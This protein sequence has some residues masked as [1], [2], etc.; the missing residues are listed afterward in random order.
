MS[1][2]VE[3]PLDRIVNVNW[4]AALSRSLTINWSADLIDPNSLYAP[5]S[6]TTM[7]VSTTNLPLLSP[8]TLSVGPNTPSD[9]F[10]QEVFG[11]FPDGPDGTING[12]YFLRQV[13]GTGNLTGFADYNTNAARPFG[14]AAVIQLSLAVGLAEL[15]R[16]SGHNWN[17]TAFFHPGSGELSQTLSGTAGSGGGFH[18][19]ATARF[20]PPS[21]TFT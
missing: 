17:A 7:T 13:F 12:T 5:G 20:T 2:Y 4:G 15:E 1:A 18:L 9:P 21:L 11:S 19:T 16:G 6:A 14:G 3:S 8:A 10:S